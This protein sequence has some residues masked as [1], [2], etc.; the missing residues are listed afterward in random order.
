MKALVGVDYRNGYRESLDQ[1]DL[2]QFPKLQVTLLHAMGSRSFSN[3]VS[4]PAMEYGGVFHGVLEREAANLLGSAHNQ[5]SGRFQSVTTFLSRRTANE[6]INE[7]AEVTNVDFIA[8]TPT[9]RANSDRPFG[10]TT[11]SILERM[12]TSVLISRPRAMSRMKVGVIVTD[13]P[14]S[15]DVMFRKLLAAP[16]CGV[17]ELHVLEL[18]RRNE[19]VAASGPAVVLST[20]EATAELD[21]QVDQLRNLGFAST[22]KLSEQRELDTVLEFAAMKNAGLLIA[23]GRKNNLDSLTRAIASSLDHSVLVYV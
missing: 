21:H 10:A 19:L 16:P 15:T 2:L 17:E 14:E 3:T 9:V 23:G 5:S 1:L 12:S 20:K 18:R 6:A 13:S 8:V 7:E 22:G 11:H 4:E